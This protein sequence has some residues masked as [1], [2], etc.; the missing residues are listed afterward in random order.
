MSY[1]KS[2]LM[3]ILMLKISFIGQFFVCEINFN[4]NYILAWSLIKANDNVNVWWRDWVVR[5]MDT[6]MK[7]ILFW[8]SKRGL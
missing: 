8:I 5:A 6:S 1:L 3:F 4:N 2:T 7:Q